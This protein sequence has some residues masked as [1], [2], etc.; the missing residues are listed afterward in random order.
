MIGREIGIRAMVSCPSFMKL[1]VQSEELKEKMQNDD[2]DRTKTTT[3]KVT[4]KSVKEA[5]LFTIVVRDEQGKEETLTIIR[6]GDGIGDFVANFKQF[7][8]STITVKYTVSEIY[9]TTTKE[10]EVKK[11][12]LS[13]KYNTQE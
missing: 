6:N 10:F 4:I 7:L 13:I 12:I 3:K 1:A 8:T 11:E 2:E 5:P 9:N